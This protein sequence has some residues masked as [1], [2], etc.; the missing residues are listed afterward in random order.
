MTMN[1]LFYLYF[2]ASLYYITFVLNIYT[3]WFDE[4]DDSKLYDVMTLI[5]VS[6][7]NRHTSCLY[8]TVNVDI[9]RA[10]KFSRIKPYETYSRS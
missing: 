4:N 7:T 9:F 8:D 10:A 5:P 6:A 3:R 2:N 1:T